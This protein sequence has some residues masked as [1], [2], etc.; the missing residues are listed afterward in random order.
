MFRWFWIKI[1]FAIKMFV[2]LLTLLFT[3]QQLILISKKFNKYLEK[4][5]FIFVLRGFEE[6]RDGEGVDSGDWISAPTFFG[7][8]FRWRG[9]RRT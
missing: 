4:L 8:G 2:I 3:I 7:K 5:K 9:I 6:G 1:N